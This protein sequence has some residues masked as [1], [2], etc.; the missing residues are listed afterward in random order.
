MNVHEPP[1]G[2]IAGLGERGTTIFEP[3]MLTSN[4][5]GFY[6]E[7]SHGIRIE[8]LVLAVE[9]ETTPYGRFLS[10]DTVSLFPIDTKLVDAK[11]MSGDKKKWLNNYHDLVFKK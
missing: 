6:E 11:L 7:G 1:Q 10:F 8:N 9:N 2:F 3:G 5:P 4:E